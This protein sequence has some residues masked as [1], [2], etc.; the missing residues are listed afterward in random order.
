MA[1]LARLA[2]VLPL[3]GAV[4]TAAALTGA[5]V[6]TVSETGCADAGRYVQHAN[7]VVELVG[8]CVGKQDFPGAPA[9]EAAGSGDQGNSAR[10]LRP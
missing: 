4:A 2:G 9:H 6:F 10:A 3:V 8:S 7:G 1:R 5:A